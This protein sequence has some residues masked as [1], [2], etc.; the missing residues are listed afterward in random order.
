MDN[1]DGEGAVPNGDDAEWVRVCAAIDGFR[2]RHGRW[3]TRIRLSRDALAWLREHVLTG[4]GFAV[5][6]SVVEL[7]ADERATMVAEDG[8]GAAYNYGKEG[9]PRLP[10]DESARAWFG[11]AILR[12]E[13][14]E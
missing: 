10:W 11:Q 4:A 12:P 6:G 14:R 2:S 9:F 1:N 8:T 13:L 3:P 7:A 5:V